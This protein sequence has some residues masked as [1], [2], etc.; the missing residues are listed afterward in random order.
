MVRSH[1]HQSKTSVIPEG[2]Q[3][4]LKSQKVKELYKFH[5]IFKEL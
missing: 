4:T 2:V 1:K 5:T 3:R